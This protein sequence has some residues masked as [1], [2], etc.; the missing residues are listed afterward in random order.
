LGSETV[1]EINVFMHIAFAIAWKLSTRNNA[2]LRHHSC[3][4]Y[5]D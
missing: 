5:Q 1:L 4:W 3:C 2:F